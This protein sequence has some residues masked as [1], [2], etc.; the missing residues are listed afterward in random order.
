MMLYEIVDNASLK[1][2]LETNDI[3]GDTIREFVRDKKLI[4]FKGEEV[5]TA[6]IKYKES[7]KA[8]IF[9]IVFFATIIAITAL[10]LYLKWRNMKLEM[11]KIDE[12]IKRQNKKIE[13]LI[14]SYNDK[15]E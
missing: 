11:K 8:E 6:S 2:L 14:K 12:E 15:K 4:A 9:L 5:T 7:H 10:I 13:P 3:Y 1:Y